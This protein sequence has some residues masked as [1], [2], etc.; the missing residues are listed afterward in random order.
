MLKVKR[1]YEEKT[2]AD[3][4]RILIDRLWPR[5]VSREKAGIDEWEKD[6]APSTELRQWFA[7][8]PDKWEEFRRKYKLE[9]SEPAKAEQLKKL[10]HDANKSD[11]T[12]VYAAKDTEHNDARVLEELIHRLMQRQS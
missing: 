9:L 4:K 8:E 12:L 7:H 3:G 1:A 6:L 11:L 2:A 5:G 10:A